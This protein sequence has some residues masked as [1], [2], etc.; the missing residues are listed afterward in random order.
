MNR[1]NQIIQTDVTTVVLDSEPP[2]SLSGGKMDLFESSNKLSLGDEMIIMASDQMV[3]EEKNQEDEI[4][5]ELALGEQDDDNNQV[6]FEDIE[7]ETSLD[8]G[9]TMDFGNVSELSEIKLDNEM[10][11]IASIQLEIDQ[12]DPIQEVS[13]VN[14]NDSSVLNS[15]AI[16][17]ESELGN[18]AMEVDQ[19]PKSKTV[20]QVQSQSNSPVD[21][22]SPK[23]VRD[24]ENVSNQN[25]I[26]SSP[27]PG[28][29][30]VK[31][32]KRTSVGIPVSDFS[33]A[34][35]QKEP[36]KVKVAVK[37]GKS[38]SQQQIAQYDNSTDEDSGIN[39]RQKSVSSP[40]TKEPVISESSKAKNST[41]L[42]TP[43]NKRKK[44]KKSEQ[45]ESPAPIVDDVKNNS[46]KTPIESNDEICEDDERELEQM[47]KSSPVV[48][49]TT[50][51]SIPSS[52]VEVEKDVSPKGSKKVTFEK[53]ENEVDEVKVPKSK[54]KVSKKKKTPIKASLAEKVDDGLPSIF[55]IPEP[56]P[57]IVQQK[58]T[59]G[60]RFTFN[61]LAQR[62]KRNA[63]N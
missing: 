63:V 3:V 22:K 23:L 44:Q 41:E 60:Y 57:G 46:T 7:S 2:S 4:S 55:D 25:E 61:I 39:A 50:S 11:S 48:Q 40:T 14:A 45:K 16:E 28:V 47:E 24:V 5:K 31:K 6:S 26:L 37:R 15:R 34:E 10:N 54:G 53:N 33:D 49:Q 20:V 32:K 38:K 52:I 13:M 12:S 51:E 8:L 18:R 62:A 36:K 9:M 58:I 1:V 17:E 59:Y 21:S 19:I 42:V 30:N 29:G 56:E 35:E 43:K 27:Q